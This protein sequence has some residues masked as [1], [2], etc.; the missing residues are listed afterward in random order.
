LKLA[1]VTTHP[2][3]YQVPFF[4]LLAS[5][6]RVDFL[7]LF[8][9]LPDAAAQGEG[10]GVEFEW[11]LPLLEGYDYEVLDN[12]AAE[13]SVTCFRG[14]DTPG[15]KARLMALEPDVIVVNGWVTKTCLQALWAAKRL[16][17]PCIVRGEANDLRL[18]PWW[19]RWLQGWLVRSYDA[20]LVIGDANREFYRRRGVADAKLFSAPYGIENER[21]ARAAEAARPRRDSLR[22]SWG[23]PVETRCLM[24]CGKFETK[25]HPVELIE[26]FEMAVAATLRADG[27]PSLHLL[28]VGDGALRAECEER[29]VKGR[30]PVTFAG[31]LNQTEIVDAYVASDGLVLPSDAGETWGLVV[32]ECMACGLPA[33]VSDQVGCAENLIDMG[34]TGWVF[35]FGDWR[36][37]ANLM[38]GFPSAA[39]ELQAMNAACRKRVADYGPEQVADGSRRAADEIL[40]RRN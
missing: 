15:I 36:D 13:P 23:I 20:C 19:K 7:V 24:F 21:F 3:Q 30:L 35:R 28:M 32:N 12:V 9:M 31:F 22:A 6:E 2:I 27:D 25:K 17:I 14:C 34:R 40:N 11:D 1:F 26:A 8:A 4:R 10:F 18:R 38:A 37:L 29:A 33:I 16:G 5:D 39:A